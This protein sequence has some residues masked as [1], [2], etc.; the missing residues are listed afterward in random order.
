MDIPLG[1]NER[2]LLNVQTF[3]DLQPPMQS[4]DGAS[5]MSN[6]RIRDAI[7]TPTDVARDEP[8]EASMRIEVKRP[9]GMDEEQLPTLINTLPME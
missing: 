9:S 8:N 6:E 3:N 7:G 2:L 5:M 4:R 1:A